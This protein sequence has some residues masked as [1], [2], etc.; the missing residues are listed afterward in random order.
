VKSQQSLKL[1]ILDYVVL[2]FFEMPLQKN[3]KN[4]FSN[5][6]GISLHE[7]VVNIGWLIH[8]RR[9]YPNNQTTVQL[10]STCRM[11]LADSSDAKQQLMRS[12]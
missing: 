5:Y 3:V 9:T 10:L 8:V 6:G 4:V 11:H 1:R 2:R 7:R 12:R